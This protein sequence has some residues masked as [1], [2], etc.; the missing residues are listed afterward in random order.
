MSPLLSVTGLSVAR[1]GAHLLSNVSFTAR[2]GEFIGVIGPNGAGKSTLLRAI[3]GLEPAD[4]ACLLDGIPTESLSPRARARRLGYLPQSREA[5]WDVTAEALVALGRYAFGAAPHRLSVA[6]AAAVAR[7]MQMADAQALAGRTVNSLSGG[8]RARVHLAR[9]LAAETPILIADEPVAAL[10]P[11]RQL[12]IMSVLR[13]RAV[14]G[15]LVIAALHE[16]ELAWRFCT[17]L[18]VIHDGRLVSD[19]EPA[20]ALS[21]ETIASVFGVKSS[22]L[23]GENGETALLFSPLRE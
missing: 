12:A 21:A 10:D 11:R 4:G 8:E 15:A 5:A 1:G 9:L 18:I 16:L 13:K 23:Y 22:S 17:R 2:A 6:D 20:Q 19:G 14:E 7:A 3:A